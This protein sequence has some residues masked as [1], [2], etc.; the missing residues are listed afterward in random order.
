M[1]SNSLLALS[2][3]PLTFAH[4]QLKYPTARGF[5][6]DKEG[7]FPCGG[8]DDVQTQRT[9]FSISGG[10]IQLEMGHPQTN[11]AVYM[12]IGDNPGTG[13][14]IVA[15]PQLT[16]D[17][18]G[19][20]CMGS[21]AVPSG[22]NVADGTKASIQVVTNSDESAGGLYQVSHVIKP[23][24]GTNSLTR[25]PIVRR[26][27]PGRHQTLPERLFHQL[28]KQHWHQGQPG[29]HL[30]QPQRNIY[31]FLAKLGQ[32]R[33]CS[34]AQGNWCSGTS[35][36]RL[37]DVGCCWCGRNDNALSGAVGMSGRVGSH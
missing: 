2:F 30:W 11:L 16:V 37:M 4:F 29:E 31:W 7:N 25:G 34:I 1:L 26:R 22:L 35:Q 17:G 36:G 27:H 9:N 21:I 5:D 20:F 24:Q 23:H 12:A 28:P 6:D 33:I 15:K 3:L 19:N 32:R 8:F 10:P 13:F 14:S 18:L